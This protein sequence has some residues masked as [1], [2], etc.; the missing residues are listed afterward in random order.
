MGTLHRMTFNDC[1]VYH[2]W[3]CRSCQPTRLPELTKWHYLPL[4]QLGQRKLLLGLKCLIWRLVLYFLVQ[5]WSHFQ[6]FQ[7]DDEA[8]VWRW[9]HKAMYLA[10]QAG[11]GPVLV[12]CVIGWSTQGPLMKLESLFHRC[13][14][15]RSCCRLFAILYFSPCFLVVMLSFIKI[16]MLQTLCTLFHV[17]HISQRWWF[18]PTK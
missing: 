6:H 17:C 8:C 1:P 13:N 12:W 4:H 9:G 10:C 5:F 3:F 2:I 16:K 18:I 7:A 14:I 11:D 15:N